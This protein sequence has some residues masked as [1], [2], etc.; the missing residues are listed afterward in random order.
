MGRTKVLRNLTLFKN[1]LLRFASV[2]YKTIKQWK[3]GD[4]IKQVLG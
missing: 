2:Y 4:L 3:P 1:L